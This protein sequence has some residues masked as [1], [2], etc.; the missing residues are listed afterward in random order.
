MVVGCG[1]TALG[2]GRQ[3]VVNNG[4]YCDNEQTV[5]IVKKE[6][7]RLHTKLSHVDTH[8]MWVSQEVQEGR[9]HMDWCP[10]AEMPADGLTKSL[11]RQKLAEFVRQLGLENVHQL[12]TAQVDT[13]EPAELR[14]WY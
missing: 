14:L 13:P 2:G 9:L 8:Q 11:V 6:D 4:I 12:L 5:G 1:L 10:T 7:A 3:S